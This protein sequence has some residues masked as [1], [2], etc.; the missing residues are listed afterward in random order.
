MNDNDADLRGMTAEIVGQ[1]VSHNRI[2]GSE[3]PAL[4]ASVHAALAG[5]IKPEAVEPE[6][7][8]PAVPLKKAFTAEFVTCLFDGKRFKSIKRHIAKDHQMTPAEYRTYWG[9]PKDS[10]MVA[11]DYSAARSGLAKQMGLGAG[12]RRGPQAAATASS[13]RDAAPPARDDV[14]PVAPPKRRGRPPRAAS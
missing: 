10:P 5:T 7:P 8:A 14:A 6:K 11:P 2:S 13:G 9:L 12:G 3:L 4:I 1:Y